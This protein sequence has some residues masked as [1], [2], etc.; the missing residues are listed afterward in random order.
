M[1]NARRAA[2][3]CDKTTQRRRRLPVR[4]RTAPVLKVGD[5]P[6]PSHHINPTPVQYRRRPPTICGCPQR[7]ESQFLEL[8][9]TCKFLN[10]RTSDDLG[11]SKCSSCAL[12]ESPKQVLSAQHGDHGVLEL[13]IGLICK[14]LLYYW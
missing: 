8:T 14:V 3:A 9:S 10:L 2:A 5:W 1:K 4:R 6:H 11:C 12:L 7:R 13:E